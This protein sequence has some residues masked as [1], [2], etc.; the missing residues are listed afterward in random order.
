MASSIVRRGPHPVWFRRLHV[1]SVVEV[2]R[3]FRRIVLEGPELEGFLSE[4]P[5]DHV[6][7][8][9]PDLETGELVVPERDSSGVT[10]DEAARA[11]MRDFT[12]RAHDAAKGELTIDFALHE[13]GIASAWATSA[14]TGASL[15][16]GGPRGSMVVPYDFDWYLLAG[17]ETALPAIARWLEELP[18]GARARVLLEVDEEEDEQPLRTTADAHVTWLH[19]R[20]CA[21]GAVSL[22]EPA[23]RSLELPAGD[24]FV[25]VAAESAAVRA[26]RDHLAE[27]GTSP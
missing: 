9:F 21:A 3:K 8:I 7:L 19:R 10:L 5:D 24:G 14:A 1:K 6:K 4:A 26:I 11:R 17:D 16:V 23:I 12:P 27:R 13:A 18:A 15:G 2:T 25:F 22:L 20:G